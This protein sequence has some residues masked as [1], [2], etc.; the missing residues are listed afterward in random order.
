MTNY[1]LKASLRGHE[2]EIGWDSSLRTYHVQLIDIRLSIDPS[3][4]VVFHAGSTQAELPTV[5]DLYTRVR[6][7]LTLTPSLLKR[8]EADRLRG[9]A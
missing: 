6:G 2:V 7:F 9:G 8:L 5:V 1:R 4:R 3:A